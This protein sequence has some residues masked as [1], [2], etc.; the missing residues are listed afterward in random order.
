ML[1]ADGEFTAGRSHV[2]CSMTMRSVGLVVDSTAMVDSRDH[3]AVVPIS[4]WAKNDDATDMADDEFYELLRRGVRVGTAAPSPGA[5]L[6]AFEKVDASNIVVLGMPADLS[7]T[8]S[9]ASVA[10]RQWKESHP[11]CEILEID[12]KT[13]AAGYGLITRLASEAIERGAPAVEV[14]RLVTTASEAVRMF[15]SLATL[16]YVARSGRIPHVVAGIGDVL[17]IKPAFEMT[18]GTTRRVGMARTTSGARELL[19]EESIRAFE[20]R[21]IRLLVIHGDVPDSAD[22]LVGRL[23]RCHSIVRCEVRRLPTAVAA[24]T[25]AGM[26]GFAALL[27]SR[28]EH[29]FW[30]GRGRSGS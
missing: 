12:T 28:V 27:A 5:F 11:N 17:G 4:V 16:H 14:R 21:P 30:L 25:G 23:E 13:A 18:L 2:E 20:G 9:S 29:G 15:G 3:I 22:E 7:G 1:H 10:A 24:H 19:V 26:V 8:A 6:Q